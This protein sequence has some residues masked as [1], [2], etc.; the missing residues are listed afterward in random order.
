[1]FSLFSILGSAVLTFSPIFLSVQIGSCIAWV[2]TSTIGFILYF[3]GFLIKTYRI[4]R[5]FVLGERK[6]KKAKNMK[7]QHLFP[8][9]GILVL[10]Q[11]VLCILWT[12]LTDVQYR[13]VREGNQ[14]VR[15]CTAVDASYFWGLAGAQLVYVILI[16][17]AA[18]FYSFRTRNIYIKQFK[19]AKPI[20]F[21]VYN[22]TFVLIVCVIVS[23]LIS[24]DP[25]TFVLVVCIGTVVASNISLITWLGPRI[26]RVILNIQ[27]SDSSGS[28]KDNNSSSQTQDK[29][30]ASG[31]TST[32]GDG[33]EAE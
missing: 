31:G 5:I 29:R 22:F 1:M 18:C 3:G 32:A 24:N 4:E 27:S 11:I 30:S 28:Q 7:N 33:V 23:S 6:F 2:W 15:S 8:G 26:V 21:S 16:I 19:E 25:S 14:I 20:L 12:V 10:I 17:V 13:D 9:L